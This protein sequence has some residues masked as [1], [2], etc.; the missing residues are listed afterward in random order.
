MGGLISTV[1]IYMLEV[2]FEILVQH[3]IVIYFFVT[4]KDQLVILCQIM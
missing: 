4:E 3:L 1:Y 2:E